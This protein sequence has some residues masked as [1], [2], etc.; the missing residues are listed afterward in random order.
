V[1]AALALE[2]DPA[3]AAHRLGDLDDA[4][5]LGDHR[6]SFGLRASNSSTTRG[7]PPVMSLVLDISRGIL[8]STSPAASFSFS[9]TA[10]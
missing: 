2:D 9:L 8:A 3:L 10:R 7:R 1:L 4:V 5:D 6:R